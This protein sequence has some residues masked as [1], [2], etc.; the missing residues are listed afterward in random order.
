MI[1]T[2]LRKENH[3]LKNYIKKLCEKRDSEELLEALD[4]ALRRGY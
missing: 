3:E 1:I 4:L 2:Q